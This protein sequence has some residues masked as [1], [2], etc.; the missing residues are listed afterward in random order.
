VGEAVPFA[1]PYSGVRVNVSDLYW[2]SSWPMDH[3]PWI[4]PDIPAPPTFA[5]FRRNVDPAMDAILACDDHLP[6]W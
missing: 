4:A 1:L 2:Q 5:A 6:G 3:R